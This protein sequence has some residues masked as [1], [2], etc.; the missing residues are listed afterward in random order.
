MNNIQNNWTCP[1]CLHPFRDTISVQITRD[2][3]L[4]SILAHIVLPPKHSVT[5][6]HIQASTKFM[7]TSKEE[8]G[9]PCQM[10]G[11]THLILCQQM[12]YYTFP[13]VPKWATHAEKYINM[14]LEHVKNLKRDL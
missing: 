8:I 14:Q 12:E 9:L 10:L 13:T 7:L 2:E 11:D 4:K 1:V 3:A 6:L 5:E